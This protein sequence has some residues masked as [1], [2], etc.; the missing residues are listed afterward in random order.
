MGI[1]TRKAIDARSHQ[2]E[3]LRRWEEKMA[4]KKNIAGRSRHLFRWSRGKI[5]VIGRMSF[6]ICLLIGRLH[7]L[8][9]GSVLWQ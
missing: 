2:A 9:R 7:D 3:G 8:I 5:M 6:S 1:F 4:S